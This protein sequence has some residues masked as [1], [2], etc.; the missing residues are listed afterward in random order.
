M[1]S[2]RRTYLENKKLIFKERRVF[3]AKDRQLLGEEKE[4]E[5]LAR[6]G[7]M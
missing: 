3:W 7:R 4:K 5:N 6:R 1:A 2:L